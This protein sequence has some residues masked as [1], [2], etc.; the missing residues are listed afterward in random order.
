MASDDDLM[1]WLDLLI[2]QTEFGNVR[3]DE[4]VEDNGYQ[5]SANDAVVWLDTRDGDGELPYVLATSMVDGKIIDRWVIY[6]S[7]I[8][9]DVPDAAP[10]WLAQRV[11]A[12]W[13]AVR[14]QLSKDPV[15][16]MLTV[17]EQ[18]PPF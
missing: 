8:D 13:H 17:L 16:Q 5:Y 6:G 3:W 10:E 4:Y 18:M 1:R 2:E 12:L 14:R 11:R 7:G 9:S 15:A